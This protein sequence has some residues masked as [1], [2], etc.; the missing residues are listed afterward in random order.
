MQVI[1]TAPPYAS[2]LEEVA[3]HPVVSAFRLNTVMPV[4]GG[5][6]EALD[7][8]A[9]LD[10]PV[11]VDLKSRQ[12]RVAE[13]AIPPFTTVRLSHSIQVNTPVDAFFNDGS[14]HARVVAVDG[15]QLILEDSPRRVVGPGE[16][17]N[18]PDPTLYVEG[19]LT[20]GDLTYLEAMKVAKFKHV[21]LSYVESDADVQAVRDILPDAELALKIES[22]KGLHFARQHRETLGQLVAAR[23]DLFIEVGAPHAI[24]PAL[25]TIIHADPNAIVASRLLDSLAFHPV[26]ASADIHDIA[27]LLSLGYKTFMLGDTV[28]LQRDSLI[29][30]LNL[31]QAMFEQQERFSK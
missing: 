5:P 26:P 24:V 7:R 10:L 19:I 11:W 12:L 23:G 28:C 9:Q 16:S 17:I 4:K 6:A 27:F 14:E 13:A 30:A 31:L 25:Q 8:L 20:E 22:Q 29:A 1:V 2:Y 21:M 18:I 15:N 3:R